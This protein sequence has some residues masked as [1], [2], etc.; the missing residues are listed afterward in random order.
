[1]GRGGKHPS[2]KG[3]QPGK[4]PW[5]PSLVGTRFKIFSK[6]TVLDICQD[7]SIFKEEKTNGQKS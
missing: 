2:F 4:A 5:V 1:M 3:K 7:L 6:M